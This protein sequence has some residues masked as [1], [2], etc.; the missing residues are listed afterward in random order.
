[1][2]VDIIPS[3]IFQG[4]QSFIFLI[5]IYILFKIFRA[6][7]ASFMGIL[8]IGFVCLVFAAVTPFIPDGPPEQFNITKSDMQY[9]TDMQT[10]GYFDYDYAVNLFWGE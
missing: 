2:S 7:L 5:G 1:M 8:V 4:F 10:K 9:I 3:G 6:G